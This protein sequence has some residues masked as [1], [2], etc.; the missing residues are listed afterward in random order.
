MDKRLNI[1]YIRVSTEEQA[2][3]GY[4]LEAQKKKI[5]AYA[6]LNEIENLKI[7]EDRG[8]SGTSLKRPAMEKILRL[9]KDG[10]VDRLIVIKLDRLSRNLIE[11]NKIINLCVDKGV[12]F[13]S[14]QED[15]NLQTAG[16]RM[17]FNIN[18]TM[19][20]FES[21]QI[22]ER[23][24]AGMKEKAR[25]G[26]YPYGQVSY[27]YYKDKNNVLH[28]KEDEIKIVKE[29]IN[30]YAFK[31]YSEKRI[32]K[33]IKDK[34]NKKFSPTNLAKFINKN[35]HYG[36]AE[37]DNERFYIIKPIINN[38]TKQA[39]DMRRKLSSYS[40][41]KYKYRNKV[42]INGKISLHTTK[43]RDDK[44][45]VYYFSEGHYIEQKQIDKHM[46]KFNFGGEL[47]SEESYMKEIYALIK[48]YSLNEINY[49][50][51]EKW[52]DH[53]KLKMQENFVN[54]ERIEISVDEAK[55]KTIKIIK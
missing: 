19:A 38:N 48:Q 39:L 33:I 16:G 7:Y 17:V 50:E 49:N 12:E 1:G 35:I 46:K 4:S 14:I 45:Y 9:I 52:I 29:M 53:Y 8:F 41:H 10:A 30:L 31:N 20:Q 42:Y 36:F 22:S 21:E 18:G 47:K 27:G 44:E 24:L 34:Y 5:E 6:F 55:N 43:Q 51:I 25:Q 2:R 11:S 15:Y 54:V 37:I 40:K 28:F 32:A 26:Q 3:E 23:T 13:D